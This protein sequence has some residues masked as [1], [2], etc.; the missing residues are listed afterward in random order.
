[1][2]VSFTA[3]IIGWS[4]GLTASLI[5]APVWASYILTILV[6]GA[7]IHAFIW[8]AV[9]ISAPATGSVPKKPRPSST[10]SLMRSNPKGSG[11]L[12]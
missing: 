7:L 6:G 9:P 12:V 1:M 5:G 4:S 8:I 11:K 10:R 2:R 3:I